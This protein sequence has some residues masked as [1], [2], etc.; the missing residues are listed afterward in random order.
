ATQSDRIRKRMRM[1]RRNAV[2][3]SLVRTSVLFPLGE[4][5]RVRGASAKE[6]EIPK[7]E[8]HLSFEDFLAFSEGQ[9]A[10]LIPPDDVFQSEEIRQAFQ[11]RLA[12]LGALLKGRVYLAASC[13]F[14][15]D[16]AKRLFRLAAFADAV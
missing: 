16:D 5:D 2:S 7:G 10:A 6:Q 13:R 4:R 11:S 9:I 15:G 8:C 1:G 3:S 12:D 14:L